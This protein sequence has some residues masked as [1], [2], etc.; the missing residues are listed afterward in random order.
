MKEIELTQ[1]KVALVSDE[2]YERVNNHKWCTNGGPD[3]Y[4]AKRGV[5]GVTQMMHRFILGLE[6]GD[7]RQVDHS[8]MNG[9]NNQRENIRICST[10]EN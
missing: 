9:L 1:G 8:D 2:D 10:G 3:N 7:K 5:K 6:I 4:Y